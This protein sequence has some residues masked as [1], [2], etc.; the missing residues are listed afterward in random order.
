MTFRWDDP[1]GRMTPEQKK[2][3]CKRTA[4][5]GLCSCGQHVDP[6][7]LTITESEAA[8][9]D[10]RG[11]LETS[12]VDGSPLLLMWEEGTGTVAAR[13]QIVPDPA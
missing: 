1:R 3:E 2:D 4:P 13:V 7:P 10:R 12:L 11:H 9:H 6:G 8:E 5:P